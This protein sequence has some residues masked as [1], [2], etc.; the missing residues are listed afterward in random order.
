[1]LSSL[2]V[3][4]SLIHVVQSSLAIPKS[5]HDLFRQRA[6][7]Q[8]CVQ[9]TVGLSFH[10]VIVKV[11]RVIFTIIHVVVV[12][13]LRTKSV[14]RGTVR[15][16]VHEKYHFVCD[17]PKSYPEGAIISVYD[18]FPKPLRDFYFSTSLVQID[19]VLRIWIVQN[20]IIN[21]KC[22]CFVDCEFRN[23]TL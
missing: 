12:F 18:G 1:M 14:S 11:P 3:S 17:S 16:V 4:R 5:I 7:F 2:S 6:R 10:C 21:V 22:S 23:H 13:V 9:A 8:I 15:V 19:F 20:T